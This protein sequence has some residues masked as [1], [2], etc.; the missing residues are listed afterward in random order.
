MD[1]LLFLNKT[2]RRIICDYVSVF[3]ARELLSHPLVDDILHLI[4]SD[5]LK[6]LPQSMLR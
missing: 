1:I 3:M 5:V 2:C 4:L 6:S